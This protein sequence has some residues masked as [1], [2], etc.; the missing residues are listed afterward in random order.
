MIP[1]VFGEGQRSC[2]VTRGQ[3]VNTLKIACKHSISRYV[4]SGNLILGMC[5]AHIRKMIPIVFGRGKW[6]FGVTS[7]QKVENRPSPISVNLK[8]GLT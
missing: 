6:S 3:M 2:G 1:I 8:L 4:T 7:G 5:M